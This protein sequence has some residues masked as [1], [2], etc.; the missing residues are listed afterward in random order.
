MTGRGFFFWLELSLVDW[1]CFGFV[2][3]LG[4]PCYTHVAVTFDHSINRAD[5]D[6]VSI[7]FSIEWNDFHSTT[8][9]YWRY[10]NINYLEIVTSGII[11]SDAFQSF[12]DGHRFGWALSKTLTKNNHFFQHKKCSN[13][14][15]RV[16]LSTVSKWQV[17]SMLIDQLKS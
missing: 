14:I 15:K 5:I 2:N 4:G 9:D 13:A 3:R 1:P 11:A 6:E 12:N 7:G 16:R 10:W 17:F 8:I